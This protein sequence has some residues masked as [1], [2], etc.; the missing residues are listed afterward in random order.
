MNPDI[1]EKESPE[2]EEKPTGKRY[3]IK[4]GRDGNLWQINIE[5]KKKYWELYT[6][7]HIIKCDSTDN[8]RSTI[9]CDTNSYIPNSEIVPNKYIIHDNGG[10]PFQVIVNPDEINVLTYEKY[11]DNTQYTI[12][13]LT[14]NG[15][16]G[17]WNGYD[18]AHPTDSRFFGNTILVQL[19]AHNYVQVGNRGIYM[20]KTTDIIFDYFS[21]VGNSNVPYPVAKGE[22]NTYFMLDC[23]YLTNKQIPDHI[24]PINLYGYYYGHLKIDN[25]PLFANLSKTEKKKFSAPRNFAVAMLNYTELQKRLW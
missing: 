22:E 10:R 13:V 14:I 8:I 23:N 1:E 11:E 16:L 4:K 15:F 5:D 3:T 7:H 21:E 17:Y 24:Q 19:N 12:P 25:N 9:K 18:P 20:F 2:P 6:T